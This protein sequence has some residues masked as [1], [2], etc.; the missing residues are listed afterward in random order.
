MF[1]DSRIVTH[2]WLALPLVLFLA[3][4]CDDGAATR[5]EAPEEASYTHLT[6]KPTGNAVL[7]VTVLKANRHPAI[8]SIVTVVALPLSGTPEE[9]KIRWGPIQHKEVKDASGVVNFSNLPDGAKACVHVRSD[10]AL[11]TAKHQ[12]LYPAPLGTVL[13]EPTGDPTQAPVLT[14]ANRRAVPFTPANYLAHCVKSPPLTLATQ[15]S[16]TKITLQHNLA[17]S[18]DIKVLDLLGNPAPTIQRGIVAGGFI[19]GKEPVFEC[20]D[21]PWLTRDELCTDDVPPGFLISHRATPGALSVAHGIPFRVEA[22]D[23]V[24]INGN[25]VELVATQ[26]VTGL[27]ALKPV[28]VGENLVCRGGSKAEDHIVDA[29]GDATAMDI[30][31]LVRFSI[32]VDYGVALKPDPSRTAVWFDMTADEGTVLYRSRTVL[33]GNQTRTFSMEFSATRDEQNRYVCNVT[34]QSGQLYDPNDP[35]STRAEVYCD[36][37]SAAEDLV[38]VTIIQRNIPAWVDHQ[39]SLRTDPDAGNGDVVPTPDRSDASRAFVTIPK[40]KVCTVPGG[41]DDRLAIRI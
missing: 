5:V 20:K 18:L 11:S 24:K 26:G 10:I 27:Q 25:D 21:I 38:R 19:G 22:L 37:A 16:H 34:S 41:N 17:V 6:D 13:Q 32:G 15:G 35:L 39:F 7:E 1:S 12:D 31:G 29:V 14:G 33:L 30:Q 9:E 36:E 23:N 40:H 4:A 28:L 3:T 2:R 8:G